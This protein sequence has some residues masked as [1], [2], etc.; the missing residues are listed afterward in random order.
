MTA[1][2]SARE[3]SEK[4]QLGGEQLGSLQEGRRSE[5]Q[6]ALV[7]QHGMER[8]GADV[9]PLLRQIKTSQYQAGSMRD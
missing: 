1:L 6:Q 5:S 2:V 7:A 4:Q 9:R 8:E 3:N